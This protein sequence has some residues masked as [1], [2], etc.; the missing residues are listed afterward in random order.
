M[1]MFC[2]VTVD[3]L[4]VLADGYNEDARFRATFDR[5][6]PALE[7]FIRSAVEIYCDRLEQEG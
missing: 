2:T 4:R 1:A 6:D 5:M 3:S 7:P